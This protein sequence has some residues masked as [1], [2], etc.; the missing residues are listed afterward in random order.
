MIPV[1]RRRYPKLSAYSMEPGRSPLTYRSKETTMTT[2]LDRSRWLAGQ[3]SGMNELT[4][5]LGKDNET[6]SDLIVREEANAREALA[7]AK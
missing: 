2:A 1:R 6:L 4:D 5:K 3:F 7:K